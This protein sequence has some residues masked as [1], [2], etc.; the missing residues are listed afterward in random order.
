[1]QY[2][3]AILAVSSRE[4]NSGAIGK[5]ISSSEYINAEKFITSEYQSDKEKC[6]SLSNQ[7]RNICMAAARSKVK[8]AKSE[9]D[10]RCRP[11]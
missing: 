2:I 3:T 6:D 5:I 8:N 9:L 11:F 7:D 10:A 1:M 4:F